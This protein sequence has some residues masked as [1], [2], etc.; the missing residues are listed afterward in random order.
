MAVTTTS[1]KAFTSDISFISMALWPPTALSCEV[2]P[3]KLNTSV[4]LSGTEPR[5][6]LPLASEVVPVVVPFTATLTPGSG[7]PSPESVT[8]PLTA[9]FC[10]HTVPAHKAS[11]RVSKHL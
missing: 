6:Y 5:V 7:E 10:A 4:A 3:I 8:R 2:K 9:R 11:S 1:C